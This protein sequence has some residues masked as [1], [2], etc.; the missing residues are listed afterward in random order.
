[1][2]IYNASYLLCV[3]CVCGLSDGGSD[4]DCT[5]LLPHRLSTSPTRFVSPEV[6]NVRPTSARTRIG[7]HFPDLFS[8]SAGSNW[9][10]IVF[11]RPAGLLPCIAHMHSKHQTDMF[12][13]TTIKIKGHTFGVS[14]L[15]VP[16]I[17]GTPMLGSPIFGSTM[18]EPPLLGYLILG[19]QMLGAPIFGLP[20]IGI[21]NTMGSPKFV[22]PKFGEV[23]WAIFGAMSAGAR[24]RSVWP[25]GP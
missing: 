19:T 8:R 6:H 12:I 11:H 14:N 13:N 16:D 10:Y 24:E 21:P 1:M 5:I 18:L 23:R 3:V 20:D 4:P 15:R 7:P 17:L 9:C 2:T 25:A 22:D